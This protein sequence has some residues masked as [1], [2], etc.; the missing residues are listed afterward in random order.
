MQWTAEPL[1]RLV[2]C[3][4]E[5]H[6]SNETLLSV[7]NT[8]TMAAVTCYKNNMESGVCSKSAVWGNPTAAASSKNG[9][10]VYRL[11]ALPPIE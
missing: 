9:Y 5:D 11:V 8:R 4:S 2:Y 7:L 6:K 1:E 10:T 3:S